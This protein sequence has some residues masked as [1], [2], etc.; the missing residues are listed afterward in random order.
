MAERD[1]I[2]A[3]LRDMRKETG[4]GISGL[5]AKVDK[6]GDKLDTHSRDDA[7][8]A[9]ALRDE[10]GEVR[11]AHARTR[12][13]VAGIVG[14]RNAEREFG[15]ASGTGRHNILPAV[16]LPTPPAVPVQ[17]NLDI[18]DRHRSSRS[19]SLR[20]AWLDAGASVLSKRAAV[21]VA[22]IV[23]S[24]A[25]G[26]FVTGSPPPKVVLVPTEASAHAPIAEATFTAVTLPPPPPPP[27]S[28]APADA[29][30]TRARPR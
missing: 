26:H 1:E 18:G 27:P 23:S 22:T 28:A 13:K 6:V 4:D 3:L 17:F 12:E 7:E 2:V 9:S 24:W 21:I 16:G 25:L 8:I 29:A 5:H 11:D 20:P 15:G 14:E 19:S 10:I 30:P